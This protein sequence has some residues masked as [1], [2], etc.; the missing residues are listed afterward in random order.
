MDWLLFAGAKETLVSGDD[1][2]LDWSL[3]VLTQAIQVDDSAT[4]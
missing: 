4:S 1:F 3:F 2:D